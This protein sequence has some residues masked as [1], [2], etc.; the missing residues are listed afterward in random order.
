[1]TQLVRII[2]LGLH[3]H[4]NSDY[5]QA[6]DAN[7]RSAEHFLTHVPRNN[8]DNYLIMNHHSTTEQRDSEKAL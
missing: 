6:M 7:E 2:L 8:Q 3:E 5:R 1:M 4:A